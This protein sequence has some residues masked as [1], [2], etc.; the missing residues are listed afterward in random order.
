MVL[1]SADPLIQPE[2]TREQKVAKIAK[3]ESRQCFKRGLWLSFEHGLKTAKVVARLRLLRDLR[4][5][6]FQGI[7]RLRR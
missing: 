3:K 5:L 4:V 6:L 1:S 2:K 7:G